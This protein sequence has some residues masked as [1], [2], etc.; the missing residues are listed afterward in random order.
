MSDQVVTS[1]SEPGLGRMHPLQEVWSIAWPTIL[2]MTSYT[3]MQFV[4]GLMVGQ[5]GPLELTAQSNGGIWAFTPLAWVM[6][7]L[8]VVNT[9]VAQNLGA[10]RPENG[11]KYAWTALWLSAVAWALIM[12]PMAL[13]MPLLFR[14]I[15]PWISAAFG[16]ESGHSAELI[17]L[18][19]GYAQILLGG[20]LLMLCA[21]GISHYFFG[22]HRP[23]VIT[24]ATISANITNVLFNYILIFGE[25]GLETMLFGRWHLDLPG[26]PGTP[27]LG[28]YGAAIGTLIGTA[29]ELGIPL[30]IFLGP[31]LNRQYRTRRA[32]RLSP[33]T[34]WEV[35]KLGWPCSIQWGNEIICWSLF[36]SVIV[37][38]FGEDHMAAG[39]VALKYMHLGFMPTVGISVAVNSLVGK[40][41]GAGKPDTAVARARL[42]LAMAVGYMTLCGL[43][44]FVFRHPMVAFFIGG[45]LAP[46]DKANIVQ[47]GG[48][49]MIC[50]AVFQTFDAFGIVY[51]GALRGAGDTLWPSAATIIYSWTFIVAGGLTLAICAP[52]LESIGPWIGAAT[53]IICYGITMAW[54][55]ESGRWRLIK[56]LDTSEE[57]AVE[58]ATVGPMPPAST[59]DSS[60]PDL[61]DATAEAV[62]VGDGL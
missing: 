38:R 62:E 52:G 32:W 15:I 10:K 55:F 26:I 31:K 36:L 56:L 20:S 30:A 43:M 50:A 58:I 11:P 18:E 9:F 12:I 44:F 6:G 17:R 60:L 37:G 34:L 2:T 46:Q 7:A 21:R 57:E 54:R 59:P 48:K 39:W 29:V 41:I 24:V 13:F 33:R 49:I 14:T 45:D 16:A 28:V 40:Y 27:A 47:I 5:V 3:I 1:Q 51:T 53:F 35:V 4:D 61:L 22:M 8:T 25:G 23:R 19:S 42:G